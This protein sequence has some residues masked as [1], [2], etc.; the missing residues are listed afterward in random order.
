M[1]APL[2][3]LHTSPHIH[4]SASTESIMRSVLL[5]L[6]PITAFAVYAFGLTAL[7]TLATA[8][9]SAAFVEWLLCRLDGRPS[10]LGDG[11]AAV[12]GLLFGLTL[13]PALPLWM[14]FVGASLCIVVGKHLFGGLGQNPFNPALVGRAILQATF[15]V[16][17]TTWLGAMEPARFGSLHPSTLT[18]PFTRPVVDAVTTATP[19][20]AWKFERVSALSYDLALGQSSGSAG[21]T[22]ALLILA[23]G[24]YLVAKGVMNWRITLAILLTVGLF[25]GA[26]HL[27][28]PGRYASPLF[29]LLS[30]G[31]LLGATFMATD[32]VGSPMTNAGCWVFGIIIGAL[33]VVIRSWGGMPEGVMYAIL[34]ANA[35]TPHIDAVIQPRV[36][37]T[38]ARR[39]ARA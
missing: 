4:G 21:E 29:M 11:S 3:E 39:R 37:G 14:V 7:L 16:P 23:G 38:G 34:L 19:L 13:P 5:A 6:L 8:T 32:P 2:L 1:K 18:A 35:L 20:A 33:V 12:T 25:S 15:P 9:L 28:D 31:V 22:C 10:S 27:T 36:Y 30:G 17:M 26:L 24:L